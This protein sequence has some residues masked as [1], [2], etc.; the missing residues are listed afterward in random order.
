M[1]K[2]RG[3]RPSKFD[4]RMVGEGRKLASY[5][6]TD[7]EMA[8][9]WGVTVKTFYNWQKEHPGFLHALKEG[10]EKP[11]AQVERSLFERA[12]GYTHD[13]VKILQYEGQPVI[14]PYTERYPP[15]STSM[16]F[17]LKN[18]RP[19]RWRDKSEVEVTGDLAERLD[20]AYQRSDRP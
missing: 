16:I 11:D 3:G 17:W 6:A 18:R 20:R 1:A 2:N 13:A 8:A 9:F 4:E 10:K 14:V 19:D 5:G 7:E 15:D 12:T